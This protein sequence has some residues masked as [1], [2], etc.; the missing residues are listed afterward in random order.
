MLTETELHQKRLRKELRRRSMRPGRRQRWRQ[1]DLSRRRF[2]YAAY[3]ADREQER[4]RHKAEQ[5]KKARET[6]MAQKQQPGLL[7]RAWALIRRRGAA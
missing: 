6:K 5:E 1:A 3:Q 2:N 4:E 7:R